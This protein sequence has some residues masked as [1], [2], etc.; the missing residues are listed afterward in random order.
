METGETGT[1]SPHRL[2]SKMDVSSVLK[3]QEQVN[4]SLFVFMIV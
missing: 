2:K 1:D 3:K 4:M